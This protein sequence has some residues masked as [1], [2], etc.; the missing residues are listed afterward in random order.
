MTLNVLRRKEVDTSFPDALTALTRLYFIP[1]FN[2]LYTP[3]MKHKTSELS[4]SEVTDFL[5]LLVEDYTFL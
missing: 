4:S 1:V 5:L 2:S 3:V